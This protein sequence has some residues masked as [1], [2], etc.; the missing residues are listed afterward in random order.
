MAR[1]SHFGL[2]RGEGVD[3]G[4]RLGVAPQVQQ[5]QGVNESSSKDDLVA[6]RK[7]VLRYREYMIDP[8]KPVR[9]TP[10]G[11]LIKGGSRLDHEPH[12]SEGASAQ[13]CEFGRTIGE[14]RG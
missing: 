13:Q 4:E 9:G 10:N 2:D 11:D 7:G 1:A 3:F 5:R 14:E 8:L 6:S 12:P